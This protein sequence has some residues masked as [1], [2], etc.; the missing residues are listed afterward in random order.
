M[1]H[2]AANAAIKQTKLKRDKEE[3][4]RLVQEGKERAELLLAEMNHRIANSLALVASLA[5]MQA[6]TVQDRGAQTA[7]QEMQVRISAIAGVHRKLYTSSDVR[8]VELGSYMHGLIGEIS[9][10]VDL[11]GRYHF[12]INVDDDLKISTDKAVSLGVIVTELV[13]NAVKYAYP[14]GGGEINISIRSCG[15]DRCRLHVEDQGVGWT[16]E[17]AVQGTGLGT[18]ITRAVACSLQASVIYEPAERGT[19]A[20]LEFNCKS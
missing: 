1:L 14:D 15:G 9:T 8:F 12:R 13:T 11:N 2:E 7:L 10:A 16:G 6:S 3:A 19:R 18:K 17:G 4:Q 20:V 5:R